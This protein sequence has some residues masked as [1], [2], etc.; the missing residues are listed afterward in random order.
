[1]SVV[2]GTAGHIDHGKTTLL[3]ALTGIDADRLPEERRRGMTIDVGY[4]HVALPDGRVVDF[5][6]V[7]GHDRLVGNML[8]GAGEIDAAM[9]VVAAD[10][11][12]N[13]QTL[14]HVEL[15]DALGVRD[16]LIAI[17]RADLVRDATR[18]HQVREAIAG[19]VS[20]TALVGAPVVVVSAMTGAGLDDLRA[21]LAVLVDVVE[22]RVGARTGGS[23][24]LA[25]D[26]VFAVKGRGTVVT[27][28]LRGG[29]I[30]PG[31]MLRVVPGSAA[32]RVREVQVRG[33]VVDE[34]GPGRAALLVGGVD[35]DALD[36]G[37]V[38]TAD[39]TIVAT[40]RL[41][42]AVHPVPALRPGAPAPRPPADRERLRLHLGTDQVEALVI[43]GPREAI[44]LADGTSVALLRLEREIAAA[45]G[46]RFALRRPSPGSTAGGGIVLDPA[47]PRGV[48]RR[49]LDVAR[50][51]ALRVAVVSGDQAARESAS[52]ELH[53]ALVRPGLM[54]RLARDVE[55]RLARQALGLVTAHHADDAAAPGMPLSALRAGVALAARR[56]VTLGRVAADAV[57]AAAIERLATDGRLVRDGDL[58]RDPARA[59]GL[60]PDVRVAM[61]RLEAALATAAPPALAEAARAAGCPPAGIRALD[62]EGRIVRLEDDLAWATTTYRDLV[63]RA[64]AMA[65][66]APLTP[67]AFRDA[68]GSSRRYVLAILEDLDRRELLRRTDA[69][70]VLGRRTLARMAARDAT[71][72][73][74]IPR[75]DRL[76]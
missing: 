34:A 70:H 11:G 36:R 57:A 18:L 21:A 13:A 31:S 1:M 42:V 49:R 60:P 74:D 52:L 55:D 71:G 29:A 23:P 72:T 33:A 20:R 48:S 24:R 9:V 26:R 69:G 43:R 27:G 53:G 40:S 37:H 19:L 51:T 64:L 3:R 58:V 7:P 16:A 35:P 10:D 38:V 54:P 25:I 45:A 75:P 22:R 68:T 47:P 14:E 30:R 66:A 6:D 12:P 73:A 65:A 41:L 2:V 8:V 28:S 44:V 5:V 61:D 17:T 59:G 4:A 56:L 39:S 15:L 67:A 50:A 32:V 76:P 46:D 63:K 62:A